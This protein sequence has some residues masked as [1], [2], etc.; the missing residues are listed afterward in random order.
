[1]TFN[2]LDVNGDVSRLIGAF[3]IWSGENSIGKEV[4]NIGIRQAVTKFSRDFVRTIV[5]DEVGDGGKY[6][7]LNTLLTSGPW[8]DDFSSIESIDFDAGDRVANDE[9]QNFLNQ[10]KGDWDFYEDSSIKYL[11]F[12]SLNPTSSQTL[13]I[14]YT[15]RHS[16]IDTADTSIPDQY[17]EAIVY[18]SVSRLAAIFMLRTEKALDPPGGAEFVS[19]RTK[20]SG[21]KSVMDVFEGFYQTEIGGTGIEPGTARR[22]FDIFPQAG[23]SYLYHSGRN[24]REVRS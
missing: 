18:L 11:F 8:E 1:M 16:L 21:F 6:Y 15:A 4:I 14:T 22:D 13:R 9:S 5:E 20:S 12:P 2:R 23:G 10:D 7:D 19:M 17:K 24:R 3:P